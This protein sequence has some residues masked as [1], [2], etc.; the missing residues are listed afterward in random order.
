[1]SDSEQVNPQV[2]GRPGDPCVFV[3][4]GATGDLTKRL[5][6]PALY[7]LRANTL[8]SDNFAI[9]GVSNLEMSS[10]DFRKQLGDEI[11]EFATTKVA[12]DLW[13]WFDQRLSYMSGDFKDPATYQRLKSELE[14]T[15]KAHGAP[16]NYLFY[17]AVAPIFFG[18]IVKQLAGAGLT[19]EPEGHWR[20]VIIEKPFGHDLESAN[21][22][23]REI[24]ACLHENQIYRI[25]H[26]L[27]KET[28]QNI[29][30]FRF[31]NGI[32]EPLWNNSYIDH[33]QITVAETVGVEHRGAFYESTGALRDMVPNHILALVSLTAMEPPNSFDSEP[34][35]DEKTK[36][37]RAIRLLKPEDVPN[38]AV[39]GQY[40]PG[41]LEGKPAPGYRSEPQV[42]PNSTTTTYV[43][44]KLAIDNWRWSGVPFYLRTGKRMAKRVTE[45]A[46]RFKAPPLMLFRQ[47]AV[48]YM[49]QNELV[50]HI[51][52]D[53]GISLSFSAKVPGPVVKLGDV[54][55]NFKYADYFRAAPAVG[56]ETLLL[57]CMIGDPSL[58]QRADT[59]DAGWRVV[60]P[61]LD[62]WQAKPARDFP[63]YAAGS[64]GPRAADELLARDGRQWRLNS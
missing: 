29:M 63:N 53:E 60:D 7:N 47:T 3:I 8:L 50:M 21:A 41:T 23:N 55:M 27:G 19:N 59:V 43:A 49:E 51:Q 48:K 42:D 45:I 32:F 52:P 38:W 15:D 25:D 26:Y 30:A 22:L 33:V 12:D 24:G 64:W 6:M 2:Q 10:E 57:D 18:E 28:V 39:R 35:R 58:F 34:V 40:G 11:R 61:I 9:I 31:G 13:K 37:L 44:M 62:A 1:M 14:K 56:Y 4:F 54:D 36:A 5:L 17:T 20:R 46:I 16:G